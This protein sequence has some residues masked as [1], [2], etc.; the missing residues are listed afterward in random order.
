MRLD[1]FL[2]ETCN[3]TRS[4]AKKEIR[5]GKVTVNSS[6]CKD[7]DRSV[8]EG[9]DEVS[10]A[11]KLI[12]YEKFVYYMLNK[13]SGVVSATEDREKTVMDLFG[14]DIRK[15][16]FP[17]GRLDKNT[18]GLLLITNDGELSHR[19]TS[20]RRKV[21]KTYLAGIA[22]P[23]TPGDIA[24][25]EAGLDI[26]DGDHSA[27]ATV[28]VIDEGS[29]FLTVTEGK[30]HEVKRMLKAV[31]NEVLS[32]KRVSFGTLKLDP[33]LKEGEFRRLTPSEIDGL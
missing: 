24:S 26:G 27:P 7:P 22:K 28:E 11:G 29:I 15:G 19:L 8:D 23:L 30:Y 16:L 13:P 10:F 32:L 14:P 5:A 1:R 3:L 2:C 6:P 9:R 17:V 31:G 18:V 20:P 4:E 21:P 12:R 25:L 33:M